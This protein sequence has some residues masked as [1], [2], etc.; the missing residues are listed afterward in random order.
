MKRKN[1]FMT[2]AL[3][4]AA[5]TALT[6]CVDIEGDGAFLGTVTCNPST[7]HEGET[8]TFDIG[9]LGSALGGINLNTEFNGKNVVKSVSYYVDGVKV[10]ESPKNKKGKDYKATFKVKELSAGEHTVTV[11]CSSNFKGYKIK[12]TVV[13]GKLTIVE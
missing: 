11:K 10:A 9:P 1:L 2:L 4:F 13:P 3:A 5:L 7:A 8:V 6:A 12:E